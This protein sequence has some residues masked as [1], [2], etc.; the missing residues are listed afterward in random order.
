MPGAVPKQTLSKITFALLFVMGAAAIAGSR[1]FAG[2]TNL[3][4]ATSDRTPAIQAALGEDPALQFVELT[5]KQAGS[6][7][8]G[9]VELR[10]FEVL[11]TAVG[12]IDF[13]Q[14]VLA[15]ISTARNPPNSIA[16]N[17]FI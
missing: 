4:A 10:D 5:E 3:E 6:L 1:Y 15:W 7:K 11:K 17:R 2:S 9:P 12:T 8:I 13:N 14:N 16:D